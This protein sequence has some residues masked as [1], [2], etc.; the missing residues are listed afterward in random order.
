M[1][2]VY[3]DV[4]G[5]EGLYQVSDLGAVK[6][7]DRYN[8]DKNGKRKFYP[9]KL[10]KF[11]TVERN[12][13][14]YHRVTL[15]KDGKTKRFQIHRLVASEFLPCKEGKECVN[16]IDNNGSNNAL[17]NLE[18]CT[19]S[20]NMIHAQRQGR[21]YKTQSRAGSVAGKASRE[22][23]LKVI[24]SDL[25]TAINGYLLL[26][27][28]GFENNRHRVKAKCLRCDSV[29]TLAYRHITRGKNTRCSKCKNVKDGNINFWK[30]R[31]MI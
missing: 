25:S 10:L 28:A 24:Q 14:T 15:S 9:G 8:V 16:H 23:T 5:Y 6:A 11:D 2:E 27:Y 17:V 30:S 21:L 20:E 26:E 22:K 19:H 29:T 1:K 31:D 4:K 7:L 3:K 12:H 13:T 18:W